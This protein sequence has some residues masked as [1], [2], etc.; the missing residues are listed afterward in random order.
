MKRY[1]ALLRGVNLGGRKLLMR[2][3]AALCEGLGYRDVTTLLA[4]G[5]VV[6]ASPQ[7]PAQVEQ[8]LE[9]ALAAHGLA[10]DVLV[11]D[12]QQLAEVVAR[13][14][15]PE[16]SADHPSHVLVTFLREPFPADALTRL[17]A[18]HAGPERLHA[19]GC[20]LYI[21]FRS[22][23]GMRDSTLVGAMR[24]ARFPAVA[25]ARNWNTVQKLA[26]LTA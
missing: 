11:R 26:A 17:N 23:Q 4:S 13:D 8:D 19:D 16:A 7:P 22:Q 2:D 5:N 20:T 21:D 18:V 14:P 9:A 12:R 24:K 10:T 15:W 25:T 6:F 1:A 3:L